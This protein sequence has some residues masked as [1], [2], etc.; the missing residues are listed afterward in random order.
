MKLNKLL[1]HIREK[2]ER[3]PTGIPSLDELTGGLPVGGITALAARPAM[4]KTTFAMTVVRNAGIFGRIPTA[5]LSFE[6][7]SEYVAKRLLATQMG[8]GGVKS[9]E[10]DPVTLTEE[11]K[12]KIGMLEQI[13][14]T[15]QKAEMGKCLETMKEAPVWIE[16]DAYVTMDELVS[17]IE[18]LKRENGIRLLV[19]DNF[20]HIAMEGYVSEREHKM[21]QL[22]HAA[23]RLK[24]AVLVTARVLRSVETRGGTKKPMLSDIENESF[25][26]NYASLIMFLYRPEYYSIYEDEWGSTVNKAYVT[27]AR[28]K[29]GNIGEVGLGFVGRA[30]FEEWPPS[31]NSLF[32]LTVDGNG[33]VLPSNINLE[34]EM[35]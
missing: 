23:E 18:R 1:Y 33:V 7:D 8:W 5:V 20:C 32:G 24:I 26:E 29:R 35:F 25:L 19:I 21:Q 11:Q 27:V 31:G 3:I 9:M 12:E 34:D 15:W 17:K 10:Y 22:L 16:H 6:D 2:E 30:W 4:G 13:G 28:N 14:F